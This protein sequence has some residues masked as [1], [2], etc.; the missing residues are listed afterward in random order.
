MK[1]MS[2]SFITDR[3]IQIFPY[4]A[5]LLGLLFG[6]WGFLKGSL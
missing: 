4:A 5:L 2:A 6:Y 3:A 1:R